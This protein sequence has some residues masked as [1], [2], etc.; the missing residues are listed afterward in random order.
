METASI[1][2]GCLSS[3]N[4][5]GALA[6]RVWLG[7]TAGVF[8]AAACSLVENLGEVPCLRVPIQLERASAGVPGA[9]LKLN[10]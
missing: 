4:F 9:T 7:A 10:R 1:N 8:P 2:L 3:V 6:S 5:L